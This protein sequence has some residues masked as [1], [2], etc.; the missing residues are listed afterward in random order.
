MRIQLITWRSQP[1]L[2][3]VYSITW[4][5]Q[6]GL[7]LRLLVVIVFSLRVYDV[8]H[9]KSHNFLLKRYKALIWLQFPPHFI[10]L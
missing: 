4:R 9:Q 7:E 3:P 6:P 10:Q 1:G 8:V 2:E 5:S